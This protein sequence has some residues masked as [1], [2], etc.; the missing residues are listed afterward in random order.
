MLT[1]FF[2]KSRP[3]NF[4]LVAGYI[5]VFFLLINFSKLFCPLFR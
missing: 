5:L 3:I 2:S 4:I 1:S